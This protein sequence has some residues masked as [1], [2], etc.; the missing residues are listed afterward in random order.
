MESW[1]TDLGLGGEDDTWENPNAANEE[2]VLVLLAAVAV[3]PERRR[4]FRE[5]DNKSKFAPD[6]IIA[7]FILILVI[8]VFVL[9]HIILYWL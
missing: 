8:L 6:A 5:E 4:K 1:N 7:L 2:N 3:A 9:V